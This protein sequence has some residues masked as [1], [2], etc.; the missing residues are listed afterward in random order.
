MFILAYSVCTSGG[1]V[2][3]QIALGYPLFAML[4]LP[5]L[6]FRK[7]E[8]LALGLAVAMLFNTGLGFERKIRS[9]YGWWGLETGSLAAQTETVD[10]PYLSGIRMS[11]PYA[12]MYEGVYE[13][14]QKHSGQ[15]DG[16]FVFPHMP[17]FYLLCDRPQ[18]SNMANVWFDVTTD[19]GVIADID[20]I[21]EAKPKVMVVCLI[22]DYVIDAHETNFRQGEKSG[23]HEMQDFLVEF[24]EE[25]QYVKDGSYTISPMYTVEVWILP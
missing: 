15:D 6:T 2:E 1:L 3:S 7:S 9:M 14:V 19:Q 17:V 18:A 11:K 25:K 8:W 16:I 21:R 4:I 13:S 23:L 10:V 12:E 24:I 22:D 20:V 5:F